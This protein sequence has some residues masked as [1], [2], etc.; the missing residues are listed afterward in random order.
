MTSASVV[1]ANET[2]KDFDVAAAP[3]LTAEVG[4]AEAE[5]VQRQQHLVEMEWMRARGLVETMKHQERQ[6]AV[7]NLG[8][9]DHRRG[10][11]T[12]D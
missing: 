5:E 10:P 11:K 8:P 9:T 2:E 1:A 7:D 12:T 3:A 4:V 6:W